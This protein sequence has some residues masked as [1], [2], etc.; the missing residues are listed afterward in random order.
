M[1][2]DIQAFFNETLPEA[3]TSN[4]D[5]AMLI[6]VNFQF[7]ISGEDG[8]EWFVDLSSVPPNV[9]Q[10]SDFATPNTIVMS[11]N[12]FRE[13]CDNPAKIIGYVDL[14]KIKF[15]NVGAGM[16]LPK[17]FQVLSLGA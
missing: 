4:P 13:I 14:G 8:G 2:V 16:K 6:G 9:V 11:S 10:G 3:L 17:L 5:A 1:A 12:T 15:G 7:I